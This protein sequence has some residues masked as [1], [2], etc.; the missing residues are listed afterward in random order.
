[1]NENSENRV[2]A[3]GAAAPEEASAKKKFN[4]G[5]LPRIAGII[6]AVLAF[7]AFSSHLLV[8]RLFFAPPPAPKR[9]AEETQV[10]EFHII[11]DLVINP[12][13]TGGR[14]HLLV[15]IGLEYHDP[16]MEE[17]LTRRDPQIRDNLITLLASQEVNTLTD[18]RYRENIRHSLLKAVNYYLEVGQVERLY[19]VKYVFQ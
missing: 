14:R 19:F 16:K 11:S 18:I 4:L 7:E 13:A 1:M 9:S 5:K 17:E 2:E 6:V 3:E 8:K 12:A 15:S 10:G